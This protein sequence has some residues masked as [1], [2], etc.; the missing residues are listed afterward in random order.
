MQASAELIQR[1]SRPV[2]RYTS[3]PTANHFS[4]AIRALHYIDWLAA[5]SSETSL[6]LYLHVP[7]CESLC[8]YCAC[9]TKATRRYEPVRQYVDTLLAETANVASLLTARSP[10][11]HIHWGGGSPSILEP[12]DI[13]RLAAAVRDRFTLADGAEFAVEIDPRNLG[14]EKVR[15]FA[16]AGVNR[17]SLGV[18][19]FE[20]RVQTAIGREQSFELTATAV[21]M[22]RERGVASVNV[23]LVYGL[24]HQTADTLDR[25]LDRVVELAPERVAAFGYAHLPARVKAQRLIDASALPGPLERFEQSTR[26]ASRLQAAGYH[27]IGLDHFAKGDDGLSQRPLRRNFQGYTSDGADVL[28]GLGASAIGKLPGGYVQNAVSTH[29]YEWLIA[30]EGLATVKG[31]ALSADDRVRAWVIERLMCDFR[32]SARDMVVAFGEAARPVLADAACVAGYDDDGLLAVTDDGI[33]VTER[34]RPF[35]RSICAA[36][37][38]YFAGRPG[39]HSAAV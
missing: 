7:F 31:I 14:A 4:P 29:E 12:E 33:E 8:H 1:Y 32:L 15:A 6:S 3:Y 36:F 26:I 22:L 16:E 21:A 27:R 19:D 11:T 9:S 37:D 18:Q 39:T 25:T 20:P 24:P 34:G 10:V 23:D 35:V 30:A 28:I 5:L 38:R 17:V 13:L 2:P